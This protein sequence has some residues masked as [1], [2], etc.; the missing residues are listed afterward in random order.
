MDHCLKHTHS[1]SMLTCP[2]RDPYHDKPLC[3]D[4]FKNATTWL[5][6]NV[7]KSFR[8]HRYI[9]ASSFIYAFSG[10]YEAR[11]NLFFLKIFI[12]TSL[13]ER[14][15]TQEPQG[16]KFSWPSPFVKFL[17]KQCLASFGVK[18]KTAAVLAENVP[19]LNQEGTWLAMRSLNWDEFTL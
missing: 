16:E 13:F 12:L 18:Q 9:T 4:P 7:S 1:L 6:L 2:L 3:D 11:C 10:F 5:I 15:K 17:F 8:M 14:M 19:G